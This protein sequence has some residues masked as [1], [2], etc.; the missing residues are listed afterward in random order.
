M[1]EFI[2]I[3]NSAICDLCN[4]LLSQNIQTIDL[5]LISEFKD[6]PISFLD[7]KDRTQRAT[8]LKRQ[9]KTENIDKSGNSISNYF[10]YNNNSLSHGDYLSIQKS[11][12]DK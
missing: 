4:V 6:P 9:H 1:L 10:Y 5:L 2:F 8:I 3:S 7:S 11:E 12:T